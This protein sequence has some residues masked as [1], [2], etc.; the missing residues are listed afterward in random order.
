LARGRRPR[1]RP[2]VQGN[3]QDVVRA[4]RVGEMRGPGRAWTTKRSPAPRRRGCE[5]GGSP[6]ASRSPRAADRARRSRCRRQPQVVV[7]QEHTRAADVLQRVAEG[8]SRAPVTRSS[9]PAAT[10]RAAPPATRPRDRCRSPRGRAANTP[11]GWGHPT[12]P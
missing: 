10:S 4:T 7:R 9:S 12:R 5:S 1:T 8:V 2:A 11:P 3:G 6:P